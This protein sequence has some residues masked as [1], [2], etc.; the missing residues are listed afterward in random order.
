LP[1][2]Q[3]CF[4]LTYCDSDDNE[5]DYIAESGL[6]PVFLGTERDPNS[7]NGGIKN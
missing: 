2:G 4:Y 3:Y 5:S 7:M 6:I 1:V